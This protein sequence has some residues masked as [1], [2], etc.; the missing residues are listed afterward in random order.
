MRRLLAPTLLTLLLL[1]RSA[2]PQAPVGNGDIPKII[3]AAEQGIACV[4]VS[5]SETYQKLGMIGPKRWPGEL[6]GV[7]ERFF[8]SS[9]I[10]NTDAE[11]AFRRKHVLSDPHHYPEAFGSGIVIDPK[12]LVLTN[13]HVVLDAVK[14]YVRLPGGFGSYADIHA[15]D[16]RSDLA[17]LRLI[18]PPRK[19]LTALPLGNADA[20]GRGQTVIALANPYAAGFH[21]G[22]PSTSIGIVS[23]VRRRIAGRPPLAENAANPLHQ[24]GI[25][26]QTDAK[27]ALG[28]SG[29]AL[30][31]LKGEAIGITTS[32]A[33]IHGTDSPGGFAL[34]INSGFRR[35]IEVLA[36]GEEVD[37]GFLG[38][39]MDK[40][41]LPDGGA[42]INGAS[43]G[44]PGQLEAKLLPKD[45]IISINGFAVRDTQDLMLGL[46][47][48]LAGQRIEIVA[49]RHGEEFKTSATLVKYN[50]PRERIIASSLGD[51]PFVGGM[52]IDYLSIL[53]HG[54]Q[55]AAIPRGV[56]ISELEAG[57]KAQRLGL[58]RHDIINKVGPV[59][60]DTPEQFYRA[61]ADQKGAVELRVHALD[62]PSRTSRIVTWK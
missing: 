39:I 24:Y 51:R 12:G 20:V 50:A 18:T 3:A 15:A 23:N 35:I 36:R 1:A 54:G 33:A 26:L 52:R 34:P 11:K 30:L 38:V 41:D 6:G 59:V 14:V 7:D 47:L 16:P 28:C 19:P 5:R 4:F 45:V 46:G 9:G 2:R 53:F 27:I 22:Q 40:I 55:Q 42:M 29:G 44:S 43:S 10:Q 48:C 25:L 62:Q 57:S 60:V 17:V 32:L 61:F 58:A 21:D 8:P 37:Y 56:L 49:V 31:N 13:Y